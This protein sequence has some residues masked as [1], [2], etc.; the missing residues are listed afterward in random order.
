M[1]TKTKAVL[2]IVIGV[3]LCVIGI[4]MVAVNIVPNSIPVAW[5]ILLL[6]GFSF[7][8]IGEQILEKIVDARKEARQ[9]IKRRLVEHG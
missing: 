6:G 4:L 2:E 3:V 9:R 5:W 7:I 8:A 1:S